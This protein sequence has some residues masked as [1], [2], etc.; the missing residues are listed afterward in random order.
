MKRDN[1]NHI[2]IIEL[3]V[4]NKWTLRRISDYFNT[5][6]HIIKRVLK[7]NDIEIRK[8]VLIKSLF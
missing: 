3:Y 8:K 1:L 5:N 4:E 2:K 7:D 6:H